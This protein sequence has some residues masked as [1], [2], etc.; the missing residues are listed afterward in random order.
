MK[1]LIFTILLIWINFILAIHSQTPYYPPIDTDFWESITP[2]ELGW[3]ENKINDF[4]EYLNEKNSKAF[5]LLK[6]GRI[7]LEK[8]FDTFT[9]DSLWYWASAG[10]TLTA[11]LVGIAQE[12]GLIDIN[13]KTSKYLGEGWTSLPKE[14]EDLI[15]VLHQLTMTTGLD[16]NVEDLDC[17]NPEC[18]KYKADAG[19]QW[20]YHNAPYTLLEKVVEKATGQNYNIYTSQK[21]RN[22]IGMNGAWIKLGFNNVYFSNARSMARFGILISSNGF[23]E[24]KNIIKDK[25]YLNQ[26]INTSQNLNKSYGYL[27]WLNGKES[28][29]IPGSTR[30]FNTMLIP[31]APFDTY[32]ALGKDGQC[33]NISPSKGLIWVRMGERPDNQFFISTNFSNEI[34]R[35]LNQIM[36]TTDLAEEKNANSLVVFPNP[37]SDYIEI[38]N[39]VETGLR[40]VSTTQEIKIFNILGECVIT[41][42]TQHTVSLQRIDISSLPVGLYYISFDD[43]VFS[44]LKVC[45]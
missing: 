24:N 4:Y 18:L 13:E 19:T 44:F 22:Q 14:K 17:T 2:T 25:T 3:N 30:V 33:L 37:A 26:M 8:Y 29:M 28:C 7:V 39:N 34:W 31:D 45:K 9:K 38:S 27:W 40:P 41:V 36:Q 20:Y 12:E 5:I 42:E 6:D 11:T 35:Y 43:R 10:K 1:S 15:K 32:A 16:Y 23:W 21:I